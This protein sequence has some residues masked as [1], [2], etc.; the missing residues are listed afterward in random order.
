MRRRQRAE[1]GESAA[2]LHDGAETGR[3][4]GNCRCRFST[5]VRATIGESF[6]QEGPTSDSSDCNVWER[7]HRLRTASQRVAE[8]R[9]FQARQQPPVCRERMR[10]FEGLANGTAS[11]DAL[12]G[13]GIGVAWG[14]C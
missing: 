4:G 3:S 13:R 10:C 11:L 8:E 6:A 12:D 14:R 9:L 2:M 1:G 5:Q 7:G